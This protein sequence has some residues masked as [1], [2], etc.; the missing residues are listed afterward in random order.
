MRARKVLHPHQRDMLE[1]AGRG[2]GEHAGLGRPVPLGQHE[3]IGA[4]GGGG[5]DDG[6]DIVRVGHLVEH[7]DELGVRRGLQIQLGEGIGEDRDPLMHR[8]RPAKPVDLARVDRLREIGDAD[9]GEAL[10]RIP[11]RQHLLDAAARVLQRGERAV[12]AIDDGQGAVLA[13]ASLRPSRRV[14]F[15]AVSCALW[16][17]P[18]WRPRANC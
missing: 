4:E 12:P 10:Q 17:S 6:A 16:F 11:R 8:V 9:L 18:A 2:L 5:A 1:P 13:V 15:G 14:S 3:R 7:D